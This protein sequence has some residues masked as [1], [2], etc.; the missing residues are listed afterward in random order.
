MDLLEGLAQAVGHMDD[1]GLAVAGDID[2]LSGV[3]E[4]VT[5]LA[6]ELSV[7]RLQVEESLSDS[8]LE[9]IGLLPFLLLDLPARGE[10]HGCKG[11]EPQRVVGKSTGAAAC[12][13]RC[14]RGKERTPE[15]ALPPLSAPAT[16]PARRYLAS[17]ALGFQEARRVTA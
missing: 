14:A 2:F 15:G 5:E 16:P 4:E 11:E 6:L 8:L 10:G 13:A 1:D 7:G 12:Q 9:L 17:A 3:D